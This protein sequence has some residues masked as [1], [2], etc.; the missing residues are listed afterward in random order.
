MK[1]SDD[2]LKNE[3]KNKDLKSLGNKI[4]AYYSHNKNNK[5][6]LLYRNAITKY[7][8]IIKNELANREYIEKKRKLKEKE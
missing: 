3:L 7:Q 4:S 2:E 5:L 1:S 6:L 8:T